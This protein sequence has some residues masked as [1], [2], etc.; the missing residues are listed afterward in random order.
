[1][2]LEPRRPAL[3]L[4]SRAAGELAPEQRRRLEAVL[5]LP[6][7]RRL[8]ALMDAPDVAQLV[9][10][11]LP[12]DFAATLLDVGLGDGDVL[13]A[14][15]A[16]EQLVHLVDVTAWAGDELDLAAT[17]ETLDLLRESDPELAL[18]WFRSADDS[19]V[20]ALFARLCVVTSD[21]VPVPG[22]IED[23][24]VDEPFS[25]DGAFLIWPRDSERVGFL[26]WFLTLLFEEHQETYLWICRSLQWVLE[27]DVEEDAFIRRQARLVENGFPRPEEGAEVFRPASPERMV[28]SRVVARPPAAPGADPVE[29]AAIT[30]APAELPEAALF[31]ARCIER[32]APEA[33]AGLRAAVGRLWRLVLAAELLHPGKP[34]DRAA[35]LRLATRTV[36][37]GLEHLSGGDPDLGASLCLARTALDLFQ[38]GHTVVLQLQRRATALRRTGWLSRVPAGVGLLEPPLRQAYEACR[39]PR[40]RRFAGVDEEGKPR[41]E[42]LATMAEVEDAR[43]ALETI[44]AL[45]RLLVDGLG[46]PADLAESIDLSGCL[47]ES[48][49]EVTAGDILRTALVH[50]AATGAVAFVPP[51]AG[52]LRSFVRQAVAS[53]TLRE[54]FR[55]E[56]IDL[57]LSRLP[58]P[59]AAVDRAVLASYLAGVLD[60]LAEEL[61]GVDASRSIDPRFV[62]GLVRRVIAAEKPHRK[63]IRT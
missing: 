31:A 58:G 4:P 54:T 41:M 22:K 59:A 39:L 63:P 45:G 10:A 37:I 16:G 18:R 8:D 28:V 35:A 48:W 25:L 42:P 50:G 27:S 9:P 33:Q 14:H 38:V 7:R 40:P 55:G 13:L 57:L 44:D 32:L 17:V 60:R 53:G 52:E 12:D 3:P 21:D 30:V 20:L 5:A 29:P 62:G 51:D 2:E 23:L 61:A 47:P 43:R 36:S 15:A 1:M 46:L 11:I 34:E 19:A 49:T 24:E 6:P 26:R 56:A